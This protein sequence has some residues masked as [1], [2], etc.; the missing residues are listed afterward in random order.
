MSW[1]L[2]RGVRF[3]LRGV[4]VGE[5]SHPGPPR[6]ELRRLRTVRQSTP[7]A[8]ETVDPTIMDDVSVAASN[9]L[10]STVPAT[11]GD[12][13][14]ARTVVDSSEDE[15]SSL[16]G[17]RFAVLGTHGEVPDRPRRRLVLVSQQVDHGVDHEW[18]SDT[19]TVAG[20]SDVEVGEILEPTVVQT[21]VAMEPRVRDL[22]ELLPASMQLTSPICSRSVLR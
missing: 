13:R 4:R 15:G 10:P 3:G 21:P 20:G 17:N 1:S 6:S 5:A 8:S 14:E 7:T 18:D 12:V 16:R 2:W 22:S 19:D 9:A 11:M